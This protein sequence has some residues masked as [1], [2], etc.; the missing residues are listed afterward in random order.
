MKNGLAGIGLHR[1]FGRRVVVHD[2]TL[3]V[4]PGEIVGLLG[5]NGAG[6]TTTFQM[7][8]GLLRPHG[9]QVYLDGEEMT[10]LP[11]WRR[12]RAGLGYLPQRSTIFRRLTVAQ[13]VQV[14]LESKTSKSPKEDAQT[15]L[16]RFG[17][18][19]LETQRGDQ[20]S[21]GERRRVELVR[22]LAAGPRVLLCDEPF[23]GLD[24]MAVD[25]ISR[26]LRTLTENG[27]GILITDH[28]VRQALEVCDRVYI[29]TD[30]TL[31]RAGTPTEI[32]ED[33]RVRAAYLGTSF[34]VRGETPP[35]NLGS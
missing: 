5:P 14:A 16:S 33:P 8:A 30:G 17:L 26:Q 34:S 22:A 28:D 11:L 35:Q 9:G 1:R 25:T 21:V 29:L 3:R 31:L 23:A 6:K 4:T 18:K 24:P 20:L 15:L 19:S 12:A 2:L 13:N 32:S 27:V 7:L 10:R